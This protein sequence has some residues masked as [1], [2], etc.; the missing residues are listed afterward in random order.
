MVDKVKVT[1]E[2]DDKLALRA[3]QNMVNGVD[4]FEKKT[5]KK[6]KGLGARFDSFVGNLAATG[7]T[8]S[9]DFLKDKLFES[10]D[11]SAEFETG[12]T[13]VAKTSNLTSKQIDILGK[14]IEDLARVVPVSTSALLSNA[15][16]AGQLGVQGSSNILKYAETIAKLGKV[17]DLEGENAASTL[18]RI[19]NITKEGNETIGTFA[20]VIVSLG[21]NFAATES[22]IARVTNEVARATQ[23]F[24]V[25]SA[26]AAALAVTLRS[27]GVRAEEAGG[28]ISK[29]FLAIEN[30]VKLGGKNLKQLERIT[31]DTGEE[32]KKQFGEDAI[33]VF[34]K[35][36]LGLERLGKEGAIVKNELETLGITGIR[37]QKVLPVLAS[38]SDEFA[39]A[40]GLANTEVKNATALNKE[41]DAALDDTSSQTQLLENAV[42]RLQRKVGDDLTGAF[43]IV[44]PLLIEFLNQLA[45]SRTET[46]ARNAEDVTVLS[47]EL[48]I[49]QRKLAAIK[50]DGV[51]SFFEADPDD[52]IRDIVAIQARISSLNTTDA[53]QQLEVLE[54][55]LTSLQGRDFELPGL[56]IFP[57][58]KD[59]LAQ[60]ENVKARIENLKNFIAV[61]NGEINNLNQKA[62]DEDASNAVDAEANKFSALDE[63][64]AARKERDL[65]NADAEK[66]AREA[67]DD[68]DF[69]ALEQSLGRKEAAEVLFRS[70]QL[71]EEGKQAKGRKLIA[72]AVEK[73]EIVNRKRKL[74]FEAANNTALVGLAAASANSI[75]QI[76]GASGKAQFILSKAIGIAQVLINS[77][78]AASLANA[79]IPF[80]GGQAVASQQILQGRIQAATIGA[81]AV[82]EFSQRF[83]SGGFVDGPRNGDRVGVRAQGGE[84]FLTSQQQRNF[85]DIANGKSGGGNGDVSA[86]INN[87]AN[88]LAGR[89]SVIAI[90]GREIF[91][92]VQENLD[93][94][95][96]FTEIGAA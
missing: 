64:A 29:S 54:K 89:E 65:E 13:E 41:F 66:L 8:R 63:L 55:Q 40:L 20:S 44:N 74:Q 35:F 1:F 18:A 17:S 76:A 25:S 21:N 82:G 3:I 47:R 60:E 6:L 75:L 90:D 50:E 7:V 37:V 16:V 14:E 23:Q 22:E 45:E 78:I 81:T 4:D 33:G 5:T 15:K 34:Q 12:L 77:N 46:F 68:A 94:G 56:R 42:E 73:A 71:T 84:A 92:A 96:Q 27:V 88:A 95:S 26:E 52:L 36:V 51:V 32:L 58:E 93:S 79:T 10:F 62:R 69:Q 70:K 48:G 19:L 86:A 53:T 80:P 87:L 30:A 57:D 91:R 43:K 49:L 9:L 72:D 59:V 28:V 11:A 39:R 85:L 67:A 61:Q 24:N 83:E 2:I 31:G 38:N